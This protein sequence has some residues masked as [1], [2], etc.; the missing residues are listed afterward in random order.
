M[1]QDCMTERRMASKSS[2]TRA[3]T[4]CRLQEPFF[5]VFASFLSYRLRVES[6]LVSSYVERLAFTETYF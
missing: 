6:P 4:N 1:A 5:F 2:S 3:Y